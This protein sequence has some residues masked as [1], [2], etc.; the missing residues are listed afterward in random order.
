MNNKYINS[1]ASLL[2]TGL[3]LTSCFQEQEVEPVDPPNDNPVVTITP[4]A[5]YSTVMEG[6][7][8]V[9]DITVDKM[10]QNPIA[11]G[12]ELSDGSSAD[13]DDFVTSGG[14]L[15]AFSPSTTLQVIVTADMLPEKGETFAFTIIPDFHW[16]WQLNP[17][18]DK[19]PVNVTV[20]DLDYSL[21]WSAGTYE[22]EDM[23][24]WG[25]D[26]DMF[27]LNAAQTEGNFDGATGACPLEQGT[28]IDLPDD[29]YD[30]YVDYYDGSI[31]AD[32]G[33]AI[34][35]VVTFSNNNGELYT[36][37][38]SFNSNDVGADT[39]IVGQLVVSGGTYTLFDADGTEIGPI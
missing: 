10:V 23:C 35:F 38:G 28:M 7:T 9:F 20:K 26:L 25:I 33:A 32:A 31:P 34:P 1:F 17:D 6:D 19:E 12:V 11:F 37:E 36:I 29:T 21:D 24:E 8:L 30:I 2:V 16:D 13:Q 5:T 14:T 4:A 3:L 39:R 27:L 15:A 18:S 22:G